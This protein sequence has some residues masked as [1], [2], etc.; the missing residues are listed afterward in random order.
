MTTTIESDIAKPS[1]PPLADETGMF[2]ALL[3]YPVLGSMDS[4]VVDL[5]LSILYA[6]A[7]SMKR[8]Y[9]LD[10]IDLR[11]ESRGWKEIID[12]R[13]KKG[14]RLVGIS[15]MTGQPLKNARDVSRYVKANYPGVKVVWGGPH[16]TVIPE[17]IEEPF[18]DFLVRGYGSQALASLI[19]ALRS[20]EPDFASIEGLSYTDENGEYRHNQRAAEFEILS[21]ED[22]PYDLIDIRSPHYERSIQGRRLFPIFTSIGCPYQC[23]FCVHPTIYKEING[24]KWKAYEEDEVIEHIEFAI[25]KY[26]ADHICFIDDTSFPKIERMRNLF[27]KI[28]AKK[29]NITM[30]FRGARI[31]EIRKMD[32][33]FFRLMIEAGGRLLMVG[34][35]SGSDRVLKGFQ[36]GIT[37]AQILEVNRT[38]AQYPE[39]QCYY[40]FI[41]GTPGETY[42]DLIET[43]KMVLQ[44][45]AE[46]PKA[47]FGFGGDWKPIPGTKTLEVAEKDFGY[48]APKTLDEWIE[49][50]SSDAADKIVHSWYTDEHNQLIKLM[51]ITSFVVDDKIIKETAANKTL[52]FRLLRTMSRAY[53]P[54]AFYRLRNNDT[55][56]LFEYTLWQWMVKAM[57]MLTKLNAKLG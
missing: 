19:E 56:F 36:K 13:L 3:V 29:L 38:L 46:N 17:T 16:V 20:D 32:D 12:E 26:Q 34:V 42:E 21:H 53:K 37:Q 22:I 28:I 31:N 33:E 40:N 43:K 23:A 10:L 14:V 2:D 24:A 54:I 8:G 48:V 18:V 47:Y 9:R 5:P 55:R 11:C 30:E 50:D 35:E 57:P 44:L 52:L 25:E 27:K 15:V 1:P 7:D 4:M 49:M 45:L 6:A 39:L 51:Q 41:Y